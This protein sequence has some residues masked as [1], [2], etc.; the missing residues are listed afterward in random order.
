MRWRGTRL[1]VGWLGEQRAFPE[2]LRQ[3]SKAERNEKVLSVF[4][5]AAGIGFSVLQ[6]F[7]EVITL[8]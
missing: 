1:A 8:R 7:R 6:N 4:D 3:R 5:H 2:S